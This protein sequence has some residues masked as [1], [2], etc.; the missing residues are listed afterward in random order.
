MFSS[1]ART[2]RWFLSAGSM[3]SFFTDRI[4]F[5]PGKQ[6]LPIIVHEVNLRY[7]QASSHTY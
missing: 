1:N 6:Q 5:T 2:L 7:E 3:R 4:F